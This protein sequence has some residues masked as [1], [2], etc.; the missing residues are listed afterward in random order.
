MR[1]VILRLATA[2]LAAALAALPGVARAHATFVNGSAPANADQ[3]VTLDVP[4]E[5]GPDIHNQ[6]VIVEV[7]GGFTVSACS[8]PAGWACGSQAAKGRTVV[9]FSR[10]G[11]PVETRFDLHVHTPAK[12]G[13][14]PF[15]VNQFYDD[16][17]AEHWDGPPDS[18]NPAP[19]L[20]VG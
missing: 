4:E 9:T 10:G 16:G 2:G 3:T 19:V 7:P 12:P 8:T 14:Y 15:Q 18:G 13:D 6:K 20:R 5:K 1:T 17:S 11:S